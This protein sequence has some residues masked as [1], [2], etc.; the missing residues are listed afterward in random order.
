MVEPSVAGGDAARKRATVPRRHNPLSHHDPLDRRMLVDFLGYA[1]KTDERV[2]A[3]RVLAEFAALC[4][5]RDE[6]ESRGS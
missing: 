6:D 4:S 1:G 5:L 3:L 2:V